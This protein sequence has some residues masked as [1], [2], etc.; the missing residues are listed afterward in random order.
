MKISEICDGEMLMLA[1]RRAAER[2]Q[3]PRY[4]FGDRARAAV[5]SYAFSYEDWDEINARF[6]DWAKKGIAWS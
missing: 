3:D 1:K 5:L 6:D 4:S 2:A